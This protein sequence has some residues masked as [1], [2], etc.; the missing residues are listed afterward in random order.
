MIAPIFDR[1]CDVIARILKRS[2]LALAADSAANALA[3][4]P[5]FAPETPDQKASKRGDLDKSARN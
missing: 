4:V 2:G 3:T 1:E 5:G